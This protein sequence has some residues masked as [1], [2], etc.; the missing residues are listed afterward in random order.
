MA[1]LQRAESPDTLALRQARGSAMRAASLAAVGIGLL[2]TARLLVLARAGAFHHEAAPPRRAATPAAGSLTPAEAWPAFFPMSPTLNASVL[3]SISSREDTLTA[4][5]CTETALASDLSANIAMQPVGVGE[6]AQETLAGADGEDRTPIGVHATGAVGHG[7]AALDEHR[8]AAQA[9]Q[10]AA[11]HAQEAEEAS[12]AEAAAL[13]SRLEAEATARRAAEQATSALAERLEAAQL[14]ASQAALQA[15]EAEEASAAEAASLTSRLEAEAAARQ[16]AEKQSLLLSARLQDAT[17]AVSVTP[18]GLVG[19]VAALVCLVATVLSRS[20]AAART[21]RARAESQACAPPQPPFPRSSPAQPSLSPRLSRP[22]PFH[23]L[24]AFGGSATGRSPRL[25]TAAL[26][27]T[28]VHPAVVA[29]GASDRRL[30]RAGQGGRDRDGAACSH[31]RERCTVVRVPAR[32][33]RSSP[34][35]DTPPA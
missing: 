16:A 11:L 12:A 14:E 28:E 15:Q 8:P 2:A 35:A 31:C 19:W 24:S 13:T 23:G 5:A 33:R 17:T 4:D 18:S 32:R 9:S 3:T 27:A 29:A 34:S 10:L 7:A 6:A 30:R 22:I 26:R 25:H 20:G 21:R 1:E